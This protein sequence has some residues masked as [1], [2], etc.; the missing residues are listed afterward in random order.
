MSFSV[1]RT[2]EL[3]KPAIEAPF[4]PSF[5]SLTQSG[6]P[7]ERGAFEWAGASPASLFCQ[8]SNLVNASHWRMVWD[9]IRFNYQS[10][11]TL[12]TYQSTGATTEKEQ[13]I[14]QWLE[15]RGYG[16]GFKRNYLIVSRLCSIH[17]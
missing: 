3:A 14:G 12:R 8:W 9:I 2:A 11:D 7:R 15:E 13:S 4:T 17:V 16:D 6:T 5:P 10:L 1:T